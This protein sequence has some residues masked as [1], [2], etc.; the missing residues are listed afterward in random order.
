GFAWFLYRAPQGD[1]ALELVVVRHRRGSGHAGEVFD[2]GV[3]RWH[4]GRAAADGT[5]PRFGRQV[6]LAGW[7]RGLTGLPAQFPV[8]RSLPLAVR[9]IDAEHQGRGSRCC[10]GTTAVL[11]PADAAGPSSDRAHLDHWLDC[12]LLLATTEDLSRARLELPGLLYHLLRSPWQELLTGPDLSH[13]P[14][15]WGGDHR[16]CN[17][18]P[19]PHLDEAGNRG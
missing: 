16:E 3:R 8:E 15:R 14:G 12:A 9:R 13:A 19:T 4:R 17:R 7:A 6:D 11:L 10:A 1:G 2:R 5:T 18:P